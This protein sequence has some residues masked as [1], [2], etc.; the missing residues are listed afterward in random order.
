MEKQ[1]RELIDDIGTKWMPSAPINYN[2]VHILYKGY[3][4]FIGNDIVIYTKDYFVVIS[5]GVTCYN[6]QSLCSI[7]MS[8]DWIHPLISELHSNF[9]DA[10]LIIDRIHGIRVFALL[11]N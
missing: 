2:S 7:Y 4:I 3:V 5:V 10:Q 11:D 6:R 9:D 8:T 1:T